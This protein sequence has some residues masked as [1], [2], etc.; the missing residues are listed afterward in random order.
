MTDVVTATAEKII[1]MSVVAWIN[2]KCLLMQLCSQF[3][4]IIFGD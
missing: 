3:H 1:N 2:L 4:L